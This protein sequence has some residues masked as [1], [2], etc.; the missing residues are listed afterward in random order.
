VLGV[1]RVRVRQ[2]GPETFADVQLAVSREANFEEADEIATHA[3]ESIREI[4]PGAD[5]MV[6]VE[7]VRAADEDIVATVR[8]LAARHGLGAHGIRV[9]DVPGNRSLDLHLEVDNSLSVGE[10]HAQATEFENALRQTL[11]RIGR[12]TTHIEPAGEVPAVRAAAPAGASRVMQALRQLPGQTGID[13]SPHDVKVNREAGH[14]DVTFHIRLDS[15]AP[16]ADAHA[17]TER[18]E[19]ALRGLVPEL[20]R[21]TIH[22]EPVATRES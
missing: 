10:A 15:G 16:I 12:I 7:P 11:P 6:H 19:Q 2:S 13:F 22:V 21:V 20:G 18:I 3:E 9:Y 4:L 1:L 14:L 17:L 8:V 5:V